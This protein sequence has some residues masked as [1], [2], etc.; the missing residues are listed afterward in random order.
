MAN[1]LGKLAVLITGDNQLTPELNQASASLKSFAKTHK[2]TGDVAAYNTRIQTRSYSQM[3]MAVREMAMGVGF[4]GS[5]FI[6][7][8]TSLKNANNETMKTIG[9]TA[10]MTGT[11]LTAV[12][13]SLQ[14]VS[15]ISKMVKAL[16]TLRNAQ[17]LA[18]AFSGPL[19]WGKLAIGAAV[20]GGTIAAVSAVSKA[21]ST[22]NKSAT[23]VTVNVAGSIKTEREITD[24]VRKG[25]VEG[26]NKNK[27]S[28]IQ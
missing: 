10:L 1:M 27:T 17:I 24:A 23:S 3:R 6:G 4:L 14:F 19:G 21:S 20:A 26:Q 8:G 22:T 9:N 15:A 12:A 13:S 16:N 18:S 25:I 5:T 28:G 2:N 11:I 7:L